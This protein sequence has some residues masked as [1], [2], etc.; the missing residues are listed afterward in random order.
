MQKLSDHEMIRLIEAGEVFESES[1]DGAFVVKIESYASTVCTAV[2][3]GHNFRSSLVNYCCLN[4]HDRLYE[5]DPYTDR[6]IDAMPITLI[7]RDSRYEYD[8]NRPLATCIYKTA[9]G[10]KVWNRNLPNK[11]RKLSASKHQAFYKVLDALIA[12]IE[13]QFGAA[14]VFD[15]HSYNH[16]R[17]E[18]ATPTFNLGTEQIDCDRWSSILNE[19]TKRLRKVELSSMPV[20][21]ESNKVFFGRGYM[22]AHINSR[23]E[24]TLVLPLEIKKIYID[25][26][27]G[28]PYPLVLQTLSQ[29]LKDCLVDVSAFFAR[30]FTNKRRVKRTDMLAEKLESAIVKV[31]RSL[32]RLAKGLETLSYINPINIQSEK[33]RFI[34]NKGNYEPNFRYRPL[35][36]DPYIFRERLYRLPVENIRDPGIQSLYRDVIDSLSGKIELLAKVGQPGFVYESLKYYGEPELIDEKNAMYL[37]HASEFEPLD[38][39]LLGTD[40]LFEKFTASA[41]AWGMNC[42]VEISSRLVASAMVSNSRKTVL[43]AKGLSLPQK[44]AHA[45]LHHELGVHMATTLNANTQRLKVFSLGLPGNTLTQEGLAILNEYQ[46]GNMTLTRLKTLALRVL[47]VKDMLKHGSFRHTFNYLSE[48][49]GIPIDDAFKLTVRV[50][51]GGGFTKDYLYLKGISQALDLYGK[52]DIRNLYVGKTGFEYLP[53]IN[54]MVERQLVNPPAFTPS[55]LH[56]PEQESPVLEYLMHCIRHDPSEKKLLKRCA[57]WTNAA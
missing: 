47:A 11:E 21:A 20:S 51:R 45:L 57:V 29:Q 16:L 9:W 55:Y 50:H 2:H 10:K 41:R 22:I 31:D 26:L 54:E 42:K 32:Y 39:A 5:E 35:D 6:F 36:I 1:L 33:K 38:K 34:H 12:K 28:E 52:Q 17:R 24:N 37:L 40:E 43:L 8:L 48:T 7:G 25:E 3:A 49:H 27:Q 44:E 18:N 13:R 15:V 53:I 30:R 23:F 14:L 46:S 19:V 56:N 4:E